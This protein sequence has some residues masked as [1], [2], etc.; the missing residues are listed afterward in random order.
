MTSSHSL[1]TDTKCVLCLLYDVICWSW[2]K[3]RT[4]TS[5][6]KKE[7]NLPNS[8]LEFR[9]HRFIQMAIKLASSKKKKKHFNRKFFYI[10]APSDK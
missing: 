1:N 4:K 8:A 9:S 5:L 7:K 2:N 6:D 10:Y 3:R